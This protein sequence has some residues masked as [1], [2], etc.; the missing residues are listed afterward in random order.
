MPVTIRQVARA[1]G[2]SRGTVDRVVNNRG[3]V[4]PE[5]AERIREVIN[6]TG[7]TPNKA[8]K[9]LVTRKRPVKI[10]CFLPS[11]GNAF[12]D[13]VIMGLRAA[14]DE[15]ADFGLSLEIREIH[16]Y[17]IGEHI[18]AIQSLVDENCSS[19][20]VS[21]VDVPD[22][23]EYINSVISSGIPVVTINTDLTGTNRL[24]YIGSNYLTGGTVAGRLL[25]MLS[26]YSE[27][28]LTIL[29]VTGSTMIKGHNDRIAGFL[30]SLNESGVEY[31]M[32]S[33]CECLDDEERAYDVT[34]DALREHPDTNCVYISA[35]GV[36]GVCRAI[37]DSGLR[38]GGRIKV[39]S[40]DNPET[41]RA[42]IQKGEIDFTICQ[43]PYRQGYQSVVSLFNYFLEN[44][45]RPLSDCFTEIVIKIKENQ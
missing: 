14:E 23:C 31:R 8:G 17:V 34:L 41:T 42:L 40:F 45:K 24:C 21:T 12:W 33:V 16:G 44:K 32:V 5:V 15:L 22:V 4:R 6:E 28:P 13:E 3:K 18:E 35:A 43:E 29:T 9:V 1:A 11:L 10:G 37:A 7:Y 27:F 20:I 30:T 19:L 25:S 38:R 39:I 36:T 26:I 2:V